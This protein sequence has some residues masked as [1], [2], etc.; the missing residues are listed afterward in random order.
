MSIIHEV[1]RSGG[2]DRRSI[3]RKRINRSALMLILGQS[4]EMDPRSGTAC[5]GLLVGN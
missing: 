1:L 5:T 4:G 2:K 3:G